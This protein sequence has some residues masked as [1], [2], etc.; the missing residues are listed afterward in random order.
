MTQ[1]DSQKLAFGGLLAMAAALGIGRFVFTPILPV[2]LEALGWSK[3]DAGLVASANFLGYLA[4]ALVAGRQVFSS[5]PRRWLLI[6]LVASAATTAGMAVP[7]QLYMLSG[8]RFI[9]GFASAF[10]IICASALVLEQLSAAGRGSLAAVH[11]AG[12]G[13]GV[14]ISAAVVETLSASGAGWRTL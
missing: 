5:N 9:G 10:V 4:G 7:S 12:V 2:M 13:T 1:G 11:F 8:L 6:A 14:V 3:V